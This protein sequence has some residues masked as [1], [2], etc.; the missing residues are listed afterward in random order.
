MVYVKIAWND[1]TSA[2]SCV[3]HC[4]AFFFIFDQDWQK[5]VSLSFQSYENWSFLD[6]FSR[7]GNF[8]HVFVQVNESLI[9]EVQE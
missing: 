7:L 1:K 9:L 2:Y 6:D 8:L 3:S 5:G 4:F